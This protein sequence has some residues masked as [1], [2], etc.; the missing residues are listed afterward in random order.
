MDFP[1]TLGAVR[2]GKESRASAGFI[3]EC[4]AFHN[5]ACD[6]QVEA[7]SRAPV[8]RTLPRPGIR[9]L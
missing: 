7:M 8:R 2:G 6:D 3:E 1:R 4:A 5:G 9:F